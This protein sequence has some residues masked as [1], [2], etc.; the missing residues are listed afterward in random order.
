MEY[1]DRLLE[2]LTG[3]AS[4]GFAGNAAGLIAAEIKTLGLGA[5]ISSDGSVY[6][7]LP[8]SGS[9]HLLIA[10]HGDEIGM[11]VTALN[12][13]G[14]IR[15]SEIGGC[16][17]RIYPGQEV[18]ILGR[19]PVNG[20][21]AV[22][23][24]HLVT[25]AERSKIM[26]VSELFIDTG[27]TPEKIRSLVRIGDTVVFRSQY[28]KL[29]P[30]LRSAKALDNRAS[31]ACGIMIL[32]DMINAAPPLTIHFAA[33]S[34]EEYTG[35]GARVFANRLELDYALVIDVCHAE[36]P[37]LNEGEFFPLNSGPAISRGG[38]IPLEMYQSL[39]AVARE[40]EIP[41]QVEP[42]PS[43]TGTDADDIAFNKEG[44]PTAILGIPLRYMHSPV[45]TVSLK[46]IE[47]TAR[48]AVGF[49]K[50]L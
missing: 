13:Q 46:D 36:F 4:I 9:K 25:A 11:M 45:E 28:R 39:V 35:L 41:Y 14:Y 47:R 38:S 26:T 20:Y 24:P 48:L 32:K 49:I 44:I 10:C 16:D 29:S 6:A 18:T 43:V 15:I 17:P 30:D 19:E 7:S 1:L 42:I 50:K 23:P 40:L 21:I 5:E 8:G 34:Q 27:L 12:E 37:D 3:A 22:K 33:T 31:V 2:S